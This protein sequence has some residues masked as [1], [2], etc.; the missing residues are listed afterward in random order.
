VWN[1]EYGVAMMSPESLRLVQAEYLEMPG[2]HLTK[3]QM[4]RLW[5][6]DQETCD[7]LVDALVTANFLKRTPRDGYVLV[8]PLE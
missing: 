8:H 5:G 4:Q 6:F 3:A 7:H 1:K 2:L